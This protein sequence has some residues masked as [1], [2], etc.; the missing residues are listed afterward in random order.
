MLLFL[1]THLAAMTSAENQQEGE[2]VEQPSF[3]VFLS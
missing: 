2:I 1:S 3:I